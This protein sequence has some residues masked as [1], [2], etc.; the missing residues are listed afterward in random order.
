MEFINLLL[1]LAGGF[2]ASVYALGNAGGLERIGSTVLFSIAGASWLNINL[3]LFSGIYLSLATVFITALVTLALFFVLIRSK[4]KQAS[5]TKNLFY[6]FAPRDE[7]LAGGVLSGILVLLFFYYANSEFLLSLAA[8]FTRE[9]ATCFYLQTFRIIGVFNPG[10][11]SLN[12]LAKA[13]DIICTP[14]NVL[15]TAT[16]LPLLK[17]SSFKI[18]YLSFNSLLFI[19]VY[20]TLRRLLKNKTTALL[21]A[22]FSVL[23]P[24]ILSVE[25]LDRNMMALSI[26]AFY[27][28]CLLAH[29]EKVFLQ[30][31]VFG[32]LA[33]TGLRFIPLT[34][35]VPTLIFWGKEFTLK[36]LLLF[37]GACL[38]TFL[39][40]LPHFF[41][42]G[43]NSLGESSSFSQ[44]FI[45]AFT[46]WGRTPFL[47]F[48]NLIFYLV[49]IINY[50]GYLVSG[51]ICLGAYYLG[52]E[53]KKYFCA[54]LSMFLLVL[55]VLSVQRNWIEADKYRIIICVF[56]PLYIF[57]GSGVKAIVACV[58]FKKM[59]PA[60][61]I[62][63]LLPVAIVNL[64]SRLEFAQDLEFYKKKLIYQKESNDYYQLLKKTL[65]AAGIFPNYSRL[66]Q[67]LNLL[68]KAKEEANTL[69]SLFA[70]SGLPGELKFSGF[71]KEWE[72][73]FAKYPHY[74][75][76][77][78]ITNP[79][80]FVA[81]KIDFEK[82][83]SDMRNSVTAGP[84]AA[85]AA[86]DLS[87]PEQFSDTF[88]AQMKVNWQDNDL[89]VC[90]MLNNDNLGI[91]K[92]LVINLNAFIS[93]GKDELGSDV[94]NSVNF[95]LN[96][97]LKQAGY[98]SGLKSFPL[99]AENK[100]IIVKVP[101]DTKII[102]K[103]WFINGDSG[104]PLKVDSW[105]IQRSFNGSYAVRF[106]Y[107][108]PESYL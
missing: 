89:L 35:I 29:K 77:E 36:R 61:V 85:M 73:S 48:P 81:I 63:F 87:S 18:L 68:R 102:I 75:E 6:I 95:G 100:S 38:I 65:S 67:K 51:I 41:F 57:L 40:N 55:V 47:P 94:V 4:N 91:F 17:L 39:F 101:K 10:L 1:M 49:N 60:L 64:S 2:L 15:F 96:P 107:N 23:N 45:L 20:L 50:F 26:S 84:A 46:K 24:Y 32:L 11:S 31:L 82:L 83:V 88:Y 9:A 54:F 52:K 8:Y 43:L 59:I 62:S 56:L 22:I 99:Y 70:G 30:G 21:V 76:A 27:F 25:V 3:A 42:N 79:D 104:V 69:R 108:E 19:F 97:G 93:L 71:Y 72:S 5:G 53:S 34:F 106:Y 13:Y 86:L 28:Y 98:D 33:G 92:E 58:N 90:V 103:N 12:A 7:L 14:G 80:D 78:L 37:T 74:P 16:L 44:L 66:F 105:L